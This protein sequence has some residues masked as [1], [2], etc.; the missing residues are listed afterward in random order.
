MQFSR[1]IAL[2]VYKEQSSVTLS[3]LKFKYMTY[4]WW[5]S[6][7]LLLYRHLYITHKHWDFWV[8]QAFWYAWYQDTDWCESKVEKLQYDC[9]IECFLGSPKL[10]CTHPHPLLVMW[11]YVTFKL[12]T[13]F[14]YAWHGIIYHFVA[15][16]IL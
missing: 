5:I 4:V 3:F 8:C 16:N 6:Q 14:Y 11:G 9:I 10:T 7:V 1:E 15:R 12:L 2:P 13:H